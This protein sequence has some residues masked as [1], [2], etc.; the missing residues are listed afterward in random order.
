MNLHVGKEY[1]VVFKPLGS[2]VVWDG[3]KLLKKS[4]TRISKLDRLI[5]NNFDFNESIF[6]SCVPPGYYYYNHSEDKIV[7]DTNDVDGFVYL[8]PSKLSVDDGIL[9]L[10]KMNHVNSLLSMFDTNNDKKYIKSILFK[11]HKKI[12]YSHQVKKDQNYKIPNHV[13]T[14][15]GYKFFFSKNTD[16]T[17]AC[18]E[19]QDA[20]VSV[21]N[22]VFFSRLSDDILVDHRFGII[23]S[24][25]NVDD[26]LKHIN[27]QTIKDIILKNKNLYY[28][29]ISVL[30]ILSNKKYDSYITD[31]SVLDNLEYYRSICR[32]QQHIV[33]FKKYQLWK[34]I[35]E[36]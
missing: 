27:S 8:K 15:L 36:V 26:K 20:L 3:V 4:G 34:D 22:Q 35:L 31:R 14:M 6:D 17:N 28:V 9:R 19:Y 25:I 12:I 32:K 21:C 18:G 30:Q 33:P 11:D 7:S 5:S 24:G 29:Y 2:C 23:D 1:S 10:I 13:I 16:V